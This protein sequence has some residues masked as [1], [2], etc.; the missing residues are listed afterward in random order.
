MAKDK[1]VQLDFHYGDGTKDSV[2][3]TVPAGEDG[4]QGM[5]EAF[6]TLPQVDAFGD[7]PQIIVR[8]Q[9]ECRVVNVPSKGIF[10]DVRSQAGWSGVALVGDTNS[11]VAS[12][13]NV[14]LTDAGKV[15]V[16]IVLPTLSEGEVSYGATQISAP[17]GIEVQPLTTTGSTR[18]YEI[19]NL[20][21]G[22]NV[23]F[24]IPVTW[25]VR[26]TFQ[27]SVTAN[28]IDPNTIDYSE[29]DDY[30]VASYTVSL[31]SEGEAT[32]DC[33]LINAVIQ[34]LPIAIGNIQ[35]LNN[36]TISASTWVEKA[37]GVK[38]DAAHSFTVKFDRPVSIYAARHTSFTGI[39]DAI[40][41]SS[42]YGGSIYDPKTSSEDLCTIKP[43][44][45][46]NDEFK[47]TFKPSS[48]NVGVLTNTIALF[49]VKAGAN[50]NTQYFA[51]IGDGGYKLSQTIEVTA[52]SGS[53]PHWW[54]TAK[55]SNASVRE[56]DIRDVDGTTHNVMINDIS[57]ALYKVEGAEMGL[58][59]GL[60]YDLKIVGTSAD[61]TRVI[62]IVNQLSTGA[63]TITKLPEG[64]NSYRMVVATNATQHDSTT[65]GLLRYTIND[66]AH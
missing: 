6:D 31:K 5:C 20:D 3:F 66:E 12:V 37:T 52:N 22:M 43:I 28:I 33:P 11:F 55:M 16:D 64:D 42:G 63:V 14:S 44:G 18:S 10:T 17:S 23:Q 34:G 25:Y 30:S 32:E 38:L 47:I 24:T 35:N 36:T 27:A 51:V 48:T 60:A 21:S 1:E 19:Q 54:K 29:S 2:K 9:G 46:N 65:N 61:G 53:L 57:N 62:P 59:A 50:C 40:T 45:S 41:G 13:R 58:M 4:S 56:F 8:S 26:G 7:E 15:R 49:C 39:Y